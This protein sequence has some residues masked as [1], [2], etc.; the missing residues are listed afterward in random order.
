MLETPCRAFL[1][2]VKEEYAKVRVVTG[3]SYK[4]VQAVSKFFE[5]GVKEKCAVKT[6]EAKPEPAK[7][8]VR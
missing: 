7:K 8:K 1:F 3:L 2:R 5:T 4:K 6:N